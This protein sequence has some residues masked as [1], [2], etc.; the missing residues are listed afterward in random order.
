MS[1]YGI[2]Y[3]GLSKYGPDTVVPFT[4]KPSGYGSI[5]LNW[6]SPTNSWSNIV[7]VR[8]P[9][10]FPI[11]P[12]D[13]TQIVNALFGSSVPVYYNDTGLIQGQYYY[14]S[15]FTYDLTLY[16]WLQVATTFG[17]SVKNFNNTQTM[18]NYLPDIYKIS[19]AYTASSDWANPTLYSFLSNFGFE[20]DTEQT[21]ASLLYSKYNPPSVNGNFVP[22]AMNQFGLTYEPA[23]GLQQNRIL[24][25]D[26]VTLATQKGSARGL[27]AY[28][29]DFTT[30]G[31]PVP[32]AGTPNPSVSGLTTGKN[33]MLD[34][35]DSSFE[36]G[37]GHW[38]S[39]DG[40]SDI[41]QL[42]TFNITSLSVTSGVATLVIG[43]HQYDVGNNI[44]ISGLPQV[45]FNTTS[46][47]TLTAVNQNSSISFSTTASNMVSSTG[48][49]QNTGA[50]GKVLPYPGAWSEPTAPVLFP[51]KTSGIIALYN[52]ST[53]NQTI[54][55]YC[56]DSAPVTMGI[57]VT[58]G[59]TYCFSVYAAQGATAKTV[60]AQIKWY[61]RFGVYLSTTTGTGVSDATATFS[62]SYR[63][64]V[65]AAA[66]ANAAYAV[67]GISIASV[68]GS[69]TNEHH[70]FDA[71]QFEVA[72]TPTAF[73][74]ARQLHIT[75]RANRINELVN[76]HFDSPVTPWTA[77]GASTTL[78]TQIA[79]PG[80]TTFAIT[81]ASIVS[82]VATVTLSTGHNL[83]VGTSVYISGVTGAASANYVG[84]R[85]ITG[86]TINT[87]TFSVTAANSTVTGGSVYAIGSALQLT[88]TTGAAGISSWD[89][90]TNAQQMSIYYPQTSYTFSI[91]VQPLTATESVTPTISWYNSS[92]TLISTTT[93]TP[94]SAAVGSWTL[95]YLTDT[96]P[97]TAAYATVGVTWNSP[98]TGH[99][100]L[101]DAAVFE[102]S[103]NLLPFF[104][105]TFGSAAIASDLLWEG[106]A[107]ASRSHYYKNRLAVQTRLYSGVLTSQL[108]LGCTY[109]VYL[110]QPQ[111]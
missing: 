38:V 5:V 81:S 43:A 82:N 52:N 24:L 17:V 41:D 35:N 15:I 37:V 7:V 108:P 67:P 51:N 49:N 65:S 64:Y 28:L 20:L 95:P 109:A 90:S 22:V 61:N 94:F 76:P 19:Q 87:F 16:K 85:V 2:N 66:P 79:E 93:G 48:Y 32:T 50:Y 56:G 53:S 26:G 91:N 98:T 44:T 105:G 77:T 78:A 6:E 25:R 101:F 13:G 110:A 102:N 3:Y 42:G 104:D 14:Y 45:F 18:Y 75:L 54:T 55:A 47:V 73:D 29:K 70:Y 103:A 10:G 9:Y 39:T 60:S 8:N 69:A 72:S 96:A 74:E 68:G 58:V 107:G 84:T 71:A 100:I 59:T 27:R 1:R 57:P 40:T 92:H 97:A 23:L 34:Y 86:V 11:N 62:A 36:E 33:L 12:W 106:T 99:Q 88:A 4:A 111:T 63:P 31:I 80:I 46:P 89:G 83:P 30:W 21:I